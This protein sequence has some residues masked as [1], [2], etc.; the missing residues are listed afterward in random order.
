MSPLKH[1][2]FF[3]GVNEID[4]PPSTFFMCAMR[5]SFVAVLRLK[6]VWLGLG[7]LLVV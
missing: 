7:F 6:G 4:P 1:R 2:C 5:A 3:R